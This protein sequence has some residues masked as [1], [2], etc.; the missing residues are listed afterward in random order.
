[1]KR[2]KTPHKCRH[3]NMTNPTKT[4]PAPKTQN[5]RLKKSPPHNFHNL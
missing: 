5:S 2:K 1:M 3:V 4:T